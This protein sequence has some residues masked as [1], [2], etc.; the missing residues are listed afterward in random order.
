MTNRKW[1]FVVMVAVAIAIS[2]FD[3][4]TLPVAIAAIQQNI[5]LSNQQFSYLQTAFLL[6]YA[7]M[8][9]LGGRLL[10][11]L[12]TRKGFLLI[13]IWWSLACA[14]H[15]LASGFMLLVIARLLLGGGEGGAFPAATRVVAEWIEPTERSTAMG[16]INAGTAV[17]SVL[18]PPVIGF[19]LLTSGW[20]TVFL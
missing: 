1:Y 9:M 14:L 20:R 19:V 7:A 11:A 12:G 16:L 18:A 13:M 17:G 10:D 6:A 4:Q 5:P 15:A 3:R 8:Y 2:Y